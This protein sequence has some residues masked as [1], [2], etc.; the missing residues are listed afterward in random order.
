MLTESRRVVNV[1]TRALVL[2]WAWR[3]GRY[4]ERAGGFGTYLQKD[5]QSIGPDRG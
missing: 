4:N 5:D 3:V 1:L 2:G